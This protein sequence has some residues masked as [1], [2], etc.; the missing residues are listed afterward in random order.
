M[1]K[2]LL[3]TFLVIAISGNIFSQTNTFPS[4]GNVGIGTTTPS[5][6]LDVAG[7]I[8]LTGDL[9]KNGELLNLGVWQQNENYPNNVIY[10]TGKNVSIGTNR[11]GGRLYVE[12][13]SDVEKIMIR[14][15]IGKAFFEFQ[16]GQPGNELGII[17][18]N[19]DSHKPGFIKYIGNSFYIGGGDYGIGAENPTTKLNV[20]GDI[21][22]TGNL[23]KNGELMSLWQQTD[24]DIYFNTGKIGIGCTPY[25]SYQLSVKGKTYLQENLYIGNL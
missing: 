20:N 16:T 2:I 11:L 23:F 13:S 22:F 15:N 19:K 14:N 18:Q 8:N 24:S 7:D 10:Y 12:G 5:K 21:N 1:R 9:Y 6:K 17:F 25:D 3:F 4:S